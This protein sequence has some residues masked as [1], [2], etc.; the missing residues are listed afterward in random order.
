M[1]AN[2]CK[3][4]ANEKESAGEAAGPL[5]LRGRGGRAGGAD[6]MVPVGPEQLDLEGAQPRR[7]RR[8]G[9]Q[10][11]FAVFQHCRSHR[12]ARQRRWSKRPVP[13]CQV[14]ATPGGGARLS[15]AGP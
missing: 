4:G 10:R 5:A 1:R 9:V 11:H 8:V 14:G 6:L 2:C 3:R 13:P 15:C 7:L 12:A